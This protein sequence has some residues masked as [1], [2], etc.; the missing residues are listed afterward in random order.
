[1]AAY[2]SRQLETPALCHARTKTSRIAA[3]LASVALPPH[4]H[5]EP[6]ESFSS[7]VLVWDTRHG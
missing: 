4:A 5:W 3:R 7:H 1:M 2:F 6:Q